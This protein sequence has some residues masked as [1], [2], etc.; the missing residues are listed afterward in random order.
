MMTNAERAKQFMAFSALKGFEEAVKIQ[1]QPREARVF[2][3]E[4]AQ[5]ELNAKLQALEVGDT[6]TAEY[7][8]GGCYVRVHGRVKKIDMNIR[9]LLLDEVRIPI[10]DLKNIYREN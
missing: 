5:Q 3:G 6:I 7:Y 10:D 2:L 8:H 4:D 9:R 1:E